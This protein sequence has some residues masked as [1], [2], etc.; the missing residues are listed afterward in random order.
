MSLQ[1]YSSTLNTIVDAM[2][3]FLSGIR[4]L[5]RPNDADVDEAESTE[6]DE[7]NDYLT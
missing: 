4:A 2:R 7:P 1:A 5:E 3:E 6:E